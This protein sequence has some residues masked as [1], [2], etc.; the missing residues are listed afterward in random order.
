MGNQLLGGGFIGF[1]AYR[2]KT[3][4]DRPFPTPPDADLISVLKGLHLQTT[5]GQFVI[6]N[7]GVEPEDL[8]KAFG[9]Y[10]DENKPKKSEPRHPAGEVY[11]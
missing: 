7:Q 8:H 1:I 6:E 9:A 10:L 4:G 3:Y 5:F 11:R 2:L